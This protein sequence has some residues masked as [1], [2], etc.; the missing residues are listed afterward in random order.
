MI[1]ALHAFQAL[2]PILIN[3]D[4][5]PA[6]QGRIHLPDPLPAL[7]VLQENIAVHR[8]LHAHF[9]DPGKY[10]FQIIQV[11]GAVLE[12]VIQLPRILARYAM[13]DLI[14]IPATIHAYFAE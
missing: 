6:P 11:V 2:K 13:M 4:A 5:K 9:A 12:E 10:Q 7:R 1:I 3:L 8:A 14:L